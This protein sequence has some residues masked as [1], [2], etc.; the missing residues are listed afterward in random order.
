MPPS[1]ESLAFEL[2]TALS[3][4]A[5]M[6][7]RRG[8]VD[9]DGNL[10]VSLKQDDELCSPLGR[11]VLV[12]LVRNSLMIKQIMREAQDPNV[13]YVVAVIPRMVSPGA[14]MRAKEA[15]MQRKIEFWSLNELQ[16]DIADHELQPREIAVNDED[17]CGVPPRSLPHVSPNDPLIRYYRIP[18]DVVIVLYSRNHDEPPTLMYVKPR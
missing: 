4:L 13:E 9:I 10:I 18:F 12:R 3:V 5:G 2:E 1:I 6:L 14:T 17:M 8:C 16:F 7:S 15:V 11:L